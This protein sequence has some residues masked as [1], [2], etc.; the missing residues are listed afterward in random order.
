MSMTQQDWQEL[1]QAAQEGGTSY[2]EALAGQGGYASTPTSLDANGLPQITSGQNL[3]PSLPQNASLQQQ[4]Q[5]AMA[6]YNSNPQLQQYIAQTYGYVGAYML[7]IPE[8]MPILIAAGLE[9]WGQGEFDSAIAQT[10]WWKSTSQAQRNFQEI[11]QTNPGEAANQVAQMEDTIL[12]EAQSLGVTIPQDQLSNLATMAVSQG[13]SSDVIQQTLRAG[14]GYSSA[15]PSFGAAATFADQARTLA[16]EYLMPMAD[17]TLQNY[18]NQNVKGTLTADGLQQQF[19]EQAMIQYP[20]MAQSIQMGVTPSQYLSAYSSAAGKTLEVDPSSINWTDPKYMAAL[21]QTNPQGQ[22][23]PVGIGEFQQNLMKN[24]AFGYQY[25]QGA[26]DQ[27]YATAQTILQTF[28]AI[29][30]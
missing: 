4:E 25:T 21:L 22:Q 3:I 8:I 30:Q 17:S 16:G 5:A 19:A 26:R 23:A 15:N 9:G 14:G 24:P 27:D 12:G 13:W 18:V 6:A 10:N 29:K 28:G 2:L 7:Q 20:W 1:E 11:Q